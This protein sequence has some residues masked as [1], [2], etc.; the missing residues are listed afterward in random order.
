MTPGT[1]CVAAGIALAVTSA[2]C[3]FLCIRKDRREQAE[4]DT[5]TRE[6]Y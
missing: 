6:R 5:Y 2:V 1:L 3:T 4:W